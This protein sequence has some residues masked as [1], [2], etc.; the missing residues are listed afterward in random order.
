[1]RKHLTIMD[2][3]LYS[4]QTRTDLMNA[5]G[6]VDIKHALMDP[7]TTRQSVYRYHIKGGNSLF[8]VVEYLQ[9]KYGTLI[10]SSIP[11]LPQGDWDTSLFINPE[12]NNTDF[13]III[14][15]LVPKILKIITNL[16]Y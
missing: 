4:D 6:D 10:E 15:T 7:E 2:S 5:V 13:Q 16:L 12:I 11:N 3:Y 14:D 8:L 9:T 1:M